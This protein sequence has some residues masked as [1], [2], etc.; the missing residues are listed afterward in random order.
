MANS[1]YDDK[2]P[3]EHGLDDNRNTPLGDPSN[4]TGEYDPQKDPM[5]NPADPRGDL[6]N[7]E[8]SGGMFNA[9][10]DSG[11]TADLS[12]K[13]LAGAEI[14]AGAATGGPAGAARAGL[15]G[16]I[17]SSAK[18]KPLI[19]AGITGLIIV[20]A[21]AIFGVSSGPMQL[22]HLSQIL[23][24]NF[25]NS[26]DA[27]ENRMN[28]LFRYARSG[29]FGETRVGMVGSK[30]FG[31]TIDQLK[32]VGIE[33]QRNSLDHVKSM[34]I[35]TGKLSKAYPELKNMSPAE[36]KVFVS[37]TFDIPLSDLGNL[38]SGSDVA[39]RK[40]GVN[41]RGYGIKASRALL[42]NATAA[43]EDGRTTSGIKFRTMAR[44]FNE[45][46]LFHPI[47][48]LTAQQEKKAVNTVEARAK[49]EAERQQAIEKPV[50]DDAQPAKDNIKSKTGGV[51]AIAGGALL[52]TAGMCIVR[53]VSDDVVK[54]N[55]AAIVAPSMLK[56]TD[57]I[58]LG[59]QVQSGRDISAG[60]V[61]AAVEGFQNSDGKGIWQAAAL[62]ATASDGQSSSGEDIS[63]GYKEAF[64]KNT[65]A[66]GI[67]QYLGGGGF[68]AIA[69]STPGI[70]VQGAIGIGL[71][72]GSIVAAIPSGGTSVAVETGKIGAGIAGTAGVIYLLEHELTNIFTDKAIVPTV[73]SGPVGGNILAYGARAAAGT[74]ARSSGGI[75][76]SNTETAV[77]DK[78]QQVEDQKSFQS[79]SYFAR[80]FDTSD[81]RSLT[82]RLADSVSPSTS[83]NVASL[84]SGFTRLGSI[85]P[86][87]FSALLPK[88]S[89]ADKPY[90][91]G[92]PIYGIPHDILNDTNLENPYDNADKVAA[93]LD[94]P[95]SKSYIDRANHCFGTDISKGTDGWDVAF[96]K[97][98]SPNDQGYI[99]AHCS[100]T[101]DYNWKRMMLFVFDTKTMDAADCYDGTSD[102]SDQSCE[103][104]GASGTQAAPRESAPDITDGSVTIK[105]LANP[106]PG[107]SCGCTI[108]PKGVTLHW[109]GNQFG[110]GITP[111]V[112]IFK[113]NHLSVQLGITSDGDV[114]QLTK[115]L[116]T[117]ANHAIGGNATTIGIEI[118]G[119]PGEFGKEGIT[120]YPDKFNAVVN[121]VKYLV[122]KYN[123]PLDG[124]ATCDNVVGIHP[125]SDYNH[126]PG[127]A[128]KSDV[129]SYYFDEVMKKVRE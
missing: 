77:L 91:W 10:G 8:K 59:A 111:L 15:K 119:G 75:E 97:A 89:A 126:C 116:N 76:L 108:D 61:G 125:H 58:A 30:V 73:T 127:A 18:K 87:A 42:K 84:A 16:I 19:G 83:Q 31:R 41:T 123:I 113:G 69:C 23:Q 112:D 82:G 128:Q 110:K 103:A 122:K 34:T 56:A 54:V 78:Q 46:S 36:Q 45:P 95:D 93:V 24:K 39:G 86:H 53:S 62:Q 92:F 72:V 65:T 64:S 90:D 37:R 71:A 63:S 28:G 79:K 20:G 32:D 124:P 101:S 99:D 88:T 26:D 38:G 12:G 57:A 120:K 100:D 68:G 48:R 27:S 80:M 98:V 49:T 104:L 11:S 106:I 22:V 21:V 96:T 51:R 9:K 25:S 4:P 52:A 94:G 66:E 118:E 40:F 85:L 81:Y 107:A 3:G 17:R 7:A 74:E 43:L 5:H 70:I 2:I 117:K 35:D 50:L 13:A 29:S 121:T 109:W 14:A 6:Q 105:K 129:D 114:Y 44:F 1:V 60:Q 67:K 33:F 102:T 55:Q 115:N 47:R